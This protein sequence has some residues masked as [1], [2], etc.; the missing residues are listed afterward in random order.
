MSDH[1]YDNSQLQAYKSCPEMYRLKYVEG[2]KRREEGLEEH[3]ANFGSAIHAGLEQ[4]YRGEDTGKVE[5][6]FIDSYPVQLDPEDMAKTQANGLLLL[7]QYNER[8]RQEDK[9]FEVLGVEVGDT[10]KCGGVEFRVKIDLVV[11]QQG[12]VY[13][14]DHKTTK[15]SFGWSY[16]G[17]FEPNSQITAYTA[18]C[19]AKYG[20]CSGGIINAIKFG[21]RQRAYKGEPAGFHSDYQRQVFNRSDQQVKA[22]V[23]DSSHWIADLAHA[24]H[25]YVKGMSWNKNEGACLFCPYKEVCISCNDEQIKEQLFEKCDPYAYLKEGK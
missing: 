25:D 22:W 20:E 12:C 5:Q 17:Q 14:M 10:F 4:L 19:I 3:H 11:R 15:K 6:A 13:F 2:L 18:Y 16:W 7:G 21:Y 24:R 1:V 23:D 8:Y 9:S